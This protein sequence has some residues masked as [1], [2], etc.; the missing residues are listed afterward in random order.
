MSDSVD[1]KFTDRSNVKSKLRKLDFTDKNTFDLTISAF[2][3]LSEMKKSKL[4]VIPS[5]KSNKSIELYDHQ[6]FAAMKV[7]NELGGSAILADEVG[8]GKTMEAGII[9]KEFLI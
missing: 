9:L 5:I 6:I 4:S 1:V 2:E 8:L 7:K 3:L